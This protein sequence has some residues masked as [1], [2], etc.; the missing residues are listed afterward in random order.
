MDM[1]IS[2]RR[3]LNPLLPFAAWYP[4]ASPFGVNNDLMASRARHP[5]METMVRQLEPRNRDLIFPYLTIFWSTG[6]QF[7]SDMM[8]RWASKTVK[9]W[10]A[11][12]KKEGSTSSAD[13]DAD[14]VRVLPLEFYSEE[15]SFF[16]H[17]PGGTWHGKDVAVVLWFVAHP[18]ILLLVP[19]IT[20]PIIVYVG[21]LRRSYGARAGNIKLLS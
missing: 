2:C 15:F 7:A 3:A 10:G 4:K 12:R 6:P 16:G 11:D 5:L 19:L 21:H 8:R 1:D 20:V 9:A 17:H 18:W 14:A 13:I